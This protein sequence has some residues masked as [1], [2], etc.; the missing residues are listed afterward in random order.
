MMF[1]EKGYGTNRT[2]KVGGKSLHGNS[3]WKQ[4]YLVKIAS[5]ANMAT[6]EVEWARG[7][8]AAFQ[9]VFKANYANPLDSCNTQGHLPLRE[10]SPN[11]KL[12]VQSFM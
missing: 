6:Q 4:S 5:Y 1:T 10:F 8:H 2:T 9:K 12:C 7:P 3:K 11:A